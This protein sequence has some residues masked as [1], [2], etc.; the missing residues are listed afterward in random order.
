MLTTLNVAGGKG[1]LGD[2]EREEVGK[3]LIANKRGKVGYCDIFGMNEGG[4]KTYHCDLRDKE[5]VRSIRSFM[6]FAG[7]VRANAT[8]TTLVLKSLSNEHVE[9]L[10]EALRWNFVL[11]ELKLEHPTKGTDMTIATLPVQQLNGTKKMSHID[12]WNCGEKK[13]GGTIDKGP[14]ARFA[15]AIVGAILA[16]NQTIQSL[17]IN[18]GP[19]SDGGGILEHL[20]RANKSSL[21][22]LDVAGIGLGDRGGSKLFESLQGGL[23]TNIH[24]LRLSGN[25]LADHAIGPLMVEV[26]RNDYCTIT[27]L[28]LSKNNVSGTV[29]ARAIQLNRSLTSH[30]VRNNPIDDQALWVLGGLLLGE[31]CLCKISSI[32]TYAFEVETHA[33]VLDLHDQKLESGAVRLLAGIVKFNT[34]L[35][36]LNLS[37]LQCGAAIDPTNRPGPHGEPDAQML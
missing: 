34:S 17:R 4:N 28:D 2:S 29:L 24:D 32:R 25:S 19:A 15:C 10:A 3:A 20:Q 37:P 13:E 18:P 9:P 35:E 27:S 21:R 14:L 33:T 26:L 22:M 30:D 5:Q 12:L 31:A 1:E 23:C 7:L 16:E 11:K 8:I 6:L 36:E